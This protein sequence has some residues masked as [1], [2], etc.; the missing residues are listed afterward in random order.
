M[1]SSKRKLARKKL[2][3]ASALAMFSIL[4]L[5]GVFFRKGKLA[6]VPVFGICCDATA[7]ASEGMGQ[8]GS[9]VQI[10]EVVPIKTC[11]D[12]TGNAILGPGNGEDLEVTGNCVVDGSAPNGKYL[13]RNADLRAS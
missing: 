9:V 6:Q 5:H 13:Y 8:T 4:V 11:P 12:D 3:I 7:G 2:I 1:A 10:Q